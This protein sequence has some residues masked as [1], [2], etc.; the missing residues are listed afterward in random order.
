MDKK[1][2]GCV[3]ISV[4]DGSVDN[5][6]LFQMFARYGV[7]ATFNIITNRIGKEKYL[8]MQQLREIYHHPL[9]EI[10][11]HSYSHKN[12]E[13]DILL[14]NENLFEWLEIEEKT[15]GFASPGNDMRLDFVR[16]NEALL[17]KYG[18]LYVRSSSNPEPSAHQIALAEQLAA[19]GAPEGVVKYVP[20]LVYRFDGMY[21]PS[22][23]VLQHTT[24]E[25]LTALADL[26]ESEGACLVFVFHRVKKPD[27][28]NWNDLWCFDYDKTEAFVRYITE[29]REAGGLDILTTRDAFLKF[30]HP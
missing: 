3:V 9:M 22:A 23:V 5:Y 30:S 19:Q 15:I 16:E 25:E 18:F 20:R 24:V 7:S 29:R 8:S 2:K 28:E 11:A 14:G 17:R 21:I 6:R 10:A 12:D 1:R 13:N 4:D 27:E 26:A